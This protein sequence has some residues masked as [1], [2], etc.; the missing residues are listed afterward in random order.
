[1]AKAKLEHRS[2][3]GLGK[4]NFHF[5]ASSPTPPTVQDHL[6]SNSIPMFLLSIAVPIA[7][8][9]LALACL[10]CYYYRRRQS[11]RL[12]T[13]LKQSSHLAN[14]HL[15]LPFHSIQPATNHLHM[16]SSASS[17]THTNLTN[18]HLRQTLLHNE[19]EDP[20]TIGDVLCE[21]S[22]SNVRF[23]QEIGEGKPSP[24]SFVSRHFLLL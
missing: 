24:V 6:T 1:M 10:F 14:T 18:L 22:A 17:S 23:L 20:A 4:S 21:I 7:I 3:L 13:S 15:L 9:C 11:H 12:S 5:L 8:T 2:D 19:S 16:P